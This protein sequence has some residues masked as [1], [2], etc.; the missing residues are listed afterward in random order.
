MTWT[1]GPLPNVWT[2]RVLLPG[3]RL[4]V[5]THELRRDEVDPLRPWSLYRL[6]A[7]GREDWAGEFATR[8]EGMRAAGGV[9]P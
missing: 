7:A 6:D 9:T 3:S 4:P 8:D 1:R 5:A 2:R